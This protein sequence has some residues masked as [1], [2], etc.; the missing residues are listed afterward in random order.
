MKE[1]G[2]VDYYEGEEVAA[3]LPPPASCQAYDRRGSRRPLGQGGPPTASLA[4]ATAPVKEEDAA[5]LRRGEEHIR[6]P[7][8]EEAAAKKPPGG[9]C[10]QE[11]AD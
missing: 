2:A 4:P 5:D 10:R 8:H 9:R 7:G 6:R 1:E 3:Q 11:D